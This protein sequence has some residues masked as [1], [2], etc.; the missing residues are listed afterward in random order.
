MAARGQVLRP[1][2]DLRRHLALQ[3]GEGNR[4]GRRLFVSKTIERNLGEFIVVVPVH[5]RS[6]KPQV[7]GVGT[8]RDARH[9][10]PE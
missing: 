6:G 9:L 4:A 8:I 2:T 5:R 10:R 3:L 7:V 1:G